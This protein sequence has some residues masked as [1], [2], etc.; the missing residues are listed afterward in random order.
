MKL[1][2]DDKGNAVL[3]DGK[4]VYVH[5]DGSE[6]PFDAAATV[7][8]IKARNAEAKTN[9]VRYEAAEA[10][11][12]A[13]EGIEP[14]AARTAIE[15][16]KNYDS[17]KSKDAAEFER[18]LSES[19]KTWQ[20]KLDAAT[21]AAAE[22]ERKLDEKIVGDAFLRSKFIADKLAVPADMVQATF[23][24]N[25]KVENGQLVAIDANGNPIMS[26]ANPGTNA[27][28]DE[29]C[30]ILVSGYAHKDSILKATNGGGSGTPAGGGS[31]GGGGAKSVK[32]SD[33]NQ[34]D[35]GA[36]AKHIRE[37]GVVVD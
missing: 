1:K 29:A 35:P 25:F 3:Q 17:S 2:L 31:G 19:N 4:P 18:R 36:Q 37:G 21:K 23:G 8:T 11:L 28:F 12:K 7:E 24:R 20:E 15:T 34:L 13:F 16:V 27:T 22:A 10:K 14:E 32:R 33:F 6:H 5:E 9:R 30:E 26:K